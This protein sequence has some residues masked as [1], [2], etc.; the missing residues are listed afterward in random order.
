MSL[1]LEFFIA[2]RYLKSK[3]KEKFISVT[4]I[5]S[6]IG[7]ALGV[8]TLII[9][10]SV[11][12]GFREELVSR[13]L[14]INSH[15]SVFSRGGNFKNYNEAINIIMENKNVKSANP[16]IENQVMIMSEDN[17]TGALVKGIKL[18]DLEKKDKIYEN[19]TT[20][21]LSEKFQENAAILG[22]NLAL[23]LGIQ[24]G[25]EIKIISPESNSTMLGNIPRI[26]TYIVVG[27]FA[28]GM[29]EYDATSIFIPLDMAQKHFKFGDSVSNLEVYLKDLNKLNETFLQLN[30]ALTDAGFNI[31]LYD[32]QSANSSFIGALKVERNV[33]F[34]I[35]TLI[36][37]VA[38][39][40]I[41]SS[42]TMLVNDKSKQIALLRTVGF[43]KTSIMR[44]FFFCGSMIGIGGTT[45][46]LI[47]GTLFAKNISNIKVWI[48]K[49]FDSTLFDPTVY[50]LTELPSKVIASDII[51][52]VVMAIFLAFLSTLYP[53]YKASKT[54]PAEV[55]RYE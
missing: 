2:L 1:K 32:W 30:R 41:I 20:K 35:L 39:F 28:S 9:V 17:T 14:G 49:I 45:L 51:T 31:Q 29:Y 5:F 36:I 22:G 27:T 21:K 34:I 43:S 8:A 11:M 23:R 18:E 10:M 42:L 7:I 37:L 3:N 26:K 50:F 38:T 48:E 44:I 24:E 46:G 4:A 12:N 55:L 25:S 6:F 52:I 54:N 40:N 33:M 19:L 16:I 15:I 13:I 47:I 53:S